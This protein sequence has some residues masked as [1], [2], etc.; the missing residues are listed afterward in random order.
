MGEGL[1][2]PP[3]PFSTIVN[4]SKDIFD[5]FWGF[6]KKQ[7]NNIQ[8]ATTMWAKHNLNIHTG[9]VTFGVLL[10]AL[11]GFVYIKAELHYYKAESNDLHINYAASRN[12]EFSSV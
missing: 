2:D 5:T 7:S 10:L 11:C 6:I 1:T 9:S 3:K 4:S 12:A 8:N